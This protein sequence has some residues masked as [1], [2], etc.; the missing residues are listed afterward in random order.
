MLGIHGG[1]LGGS[2]ME[3]GVVELVDG[4]VIKHVST[5]NIGQALERA[6]VLVVIAIDMEA[7]HATLDIFA[8]EQIVPKLR[9]RVGSSETTC[10]ADNGNIWCVLLHVD[11]TG[12]SR[13]LQIR[14][15]AMLLLRRVS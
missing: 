2:D 9:R 15:K 14:R 11:R 7:G 3:E 5:V 1:S 13:L 4:I 12:Y 10:Q 8:H 6:A